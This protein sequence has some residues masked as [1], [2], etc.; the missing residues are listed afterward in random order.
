MR[1]RAAWLLTLTLTVGPFTAQGG[2]AV[3]V[4]EYQIKAA[5]IYKFSTYIR[6][7]E[8]QSSDPGTPFVIGVFGKDPFGPALAEVVKGK[9]VQGRAV[10]VRNVARLEEASSCNVLFVSSSER[11]H[12]QQII[13]VLHQAPVLT[14]GDMDQFAELGGMINLITIE[15]NQIRFDI[16]KGQIDRAG[17]K[18]PAQLLRLARI[19][20]SRPG[21]G[22]R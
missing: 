19:V 8:A 21:G 9:S 5:F 16:N 10:V 4:P 18:A 7:P 14:V 6:W 2:S 20:E 13:A 17:L 3:T 15:E 11:E 22:K 12:L 1:P